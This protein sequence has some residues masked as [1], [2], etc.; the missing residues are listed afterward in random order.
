MTSGKLERVLSSFKFT[1]FFKPFE[2]K[3][4]IRSFYRIEEV[5]KYSRPIEFCQPYIYHQFQVV[6]LYSQSAI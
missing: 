2:E 1:F 3:K 4:C 6:T 5:K